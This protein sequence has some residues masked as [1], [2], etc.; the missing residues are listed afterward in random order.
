[1]SKVTSSAYE[2]IRS[3]ILH[4][5]FAP[6]SQLKEEELAVLCGVSRTPV[7]EAL[8]R[9]ESEMLV[10]RTRTQRSYV[11]DWSNAEIKEIFTLRGI[12]EGHAAALAAEEMTDAELRK[13]RASNYE[14]RK[15]IDRKPKPDVKSFLECNHQFHNIIIG[16]SGSKRLKAIVFRL[17]EQPIVYRTALGY[18]RQS[19]ETSHR[20][21]EELTMAIAKRDAEWARIIMSGHIRRAFHI[22][23]ENYIV[24]R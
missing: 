15:A 13:L 18:D 2:K 12:L 20:E 6:G 11:T 5:T 17:V 14:L 9:L 8:C 3:H 24:D 16:A 22:Y 21:H 19:L 23:A 4:G 7:R 1:M 10:R